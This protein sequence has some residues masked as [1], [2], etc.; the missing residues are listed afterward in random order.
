MVKNDEG[1]KLVHQTNTNARKPV[2]TAEAIFKEFPL[3]DTYK[4]GENK[5]KEGKIDIRGR[6]IN[7]YGQKKV[8][9]VKEGDK[10][11]TAEKRKRWFK[12]GLGRI[13]WLMERCP[14]G[15]EKY[16]QRICVPQKIG[17]A[18]AGGKEEE[19]RE[20]IE[21]WAIEMKEK[22]IKTEVIIVKWK[23]DNNKRKE[24]NKNKGEKK[25]KK[26]ST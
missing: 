9:K 20:M 22:G 7:L 25:R 4:N 1:G 17:C 15:Q 11:E 18:I 12:E 14:K 5:G 6:I 10:E 24:E 19:Y 8:S 21:E 3:A 23:T 16:W 26:E 13:T 2:G